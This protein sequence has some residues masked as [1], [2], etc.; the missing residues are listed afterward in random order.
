MYCCLVRLV[1]H[2]FI[3]VL[4]RRVPICWHTFHLRFQDIYQWA[5]ESV[6]AVVYDCHIGSMDPN[7]PA[8][9]WQHQF[10]DSFNFII[11]VFLKLFFDPREKIMEKCGIR[12]KTWQEFVSRMR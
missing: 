9:S 4:P 6:C 7:L 5:L 3:Q 10:I 1:F 8:D 12:S 2:Q 11:N